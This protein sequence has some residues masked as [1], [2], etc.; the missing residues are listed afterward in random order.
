MR[1]WNASVTGR[2]HYIQVITITETKADAQA[3]A[4]AVVKRVQVLLSALA[5]H[6]LIH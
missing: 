2:S 6:L 3:I 5:F 4:N 1:L